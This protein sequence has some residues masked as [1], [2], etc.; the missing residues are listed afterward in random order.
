[1]NSVC[2]IGFLREKIDD[3]Y[4]YFEYE[5]PYFDENENAKTI[6]VVKFWANQPNAR[7]I[8]MPENSRVAIRGHLDAHE[9]YGTI[10][11]VEQIQ[12]VK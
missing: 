12:S 6:I 11:V 9:K 10:I 8:S 7:L 4:R 2:I 5:L 3:I 1:M